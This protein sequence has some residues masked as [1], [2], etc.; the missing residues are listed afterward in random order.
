S[1]LDQIVKMLLARVERPEASDCSNKEAWM[2]LCLQDTGVLFQDSMVAVMYRRCIRSRGVASIR[3][4]VVRINDD[5]DA[6]YGIGCVQINDD[7]NWISV[8]QIS[9]TSTEGAAVELEIEHR[10]VIA[11]PVAVQ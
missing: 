1:D 10:C 7:I 2:R 3:L 11:D 6:P 5:A 4:Q 9:G 8:E